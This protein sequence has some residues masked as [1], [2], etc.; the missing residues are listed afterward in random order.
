MDT[1]LAQ[2]YSPIEIIVVDDHSTDDSADVL[3]EYA[4]CPNVKLVLLPENKGYPAACN[5]GVSLSQ[6]EFVMFAEC[7]DYSGPDQIAVLIQALIKHPSVGASY[8]R[9]NIVDGGG[10]WLGDDFKGRD[11]A[12]RLL[13]R[14]D[15]LIP[16]ETMRNFLLVSCVIPNMSAVLFKKACFQQAG[17]ISPAY[18]S[19]ADWHF[20][21]R[22]AETCDF[23][24]SS[25]SLNNFRTHPGTV[26][27]TFSLA[28]QL[29]EMFDLL[30]EAYGRNPASLVSSL[31]FRVNI[32]YIWAAHFFSRPSEW[33]MSFPRIWANNF[34]HERVGIV[35]LIGGF[36][37][38]IKIKLCRMLG[39]IRLL[40]NCSL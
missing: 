31:L 15:V 28:L 35:Y 39:G 9:S 22:M 27:S 29:S 2:T 11:R 38:W 33:L 14:S 17:G 1:L 7:D 10:R 24:Y 21:L 5:L 6:G 37:V 20:W 12:F 34:K 13:C 8:S 32:G 23:F 18:K 16:R 26:R 25:E 36:V 19:C 4:K 30:Y 40:V 3:Q